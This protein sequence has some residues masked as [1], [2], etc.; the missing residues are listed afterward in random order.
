MFA[1]RYTAFVDAC[2]LASV[3]RRN[4]LLSLAEAEFFRLRWSERILD[5][6]QAAIDKMTERKGMPDHAGRAARARQAMQTAF[7]DAMVADY[8]HYL[9][10]ASG[11]PDPEDAHVVAAALKT[12]AQT[13]I[14]ENLRDFPPDLLDP[15]GIEARSADDFIADTIAL[16]P[17]RA[18]PAIRRM[19][20]RFRNPAMTA[21]TLLIDMEAHGLLATVDTLAPFSGSL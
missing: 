4:L 21:A 5:E 11:L 1:N 13:I 19:R 2:S 10:L 3:M 15:L 20:L 8:A 7:E 16:D 6:T 9:P 18:I 12:Q 14:T 17:G